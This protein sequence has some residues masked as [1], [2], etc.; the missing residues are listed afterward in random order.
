MVAGEHSGDA[1]GAKLMAALERAPP[2]PHP[3]PR[4]R[5]RADGAAGPRLAVSDRG[6][7]GD[8]GRRRSSRGCPRSC[9]ASTAPSPRP[10]R[11]SPMRSSSSTAPSSRIR[12]PG[13]CGGA[14]PD[15]PHHRL[16]LAERVGLAAGPGAQDARLRRSRAGAAAVRAGRARR[17]GGPPCTYV[18]HPLIE[19][20]PWIAALDTGAAGRAPGAARPTRRCS[21][22]CRAAAPRR[23]SA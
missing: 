3:L 15:D 18:G 21:S 8:G 9:A 14:R 12:S 1:L 6:R 23:S 19:R 17:L 13:A 5:R 22:C 10:S 16:R 20:L 4:R 11:P 2:R 7:G